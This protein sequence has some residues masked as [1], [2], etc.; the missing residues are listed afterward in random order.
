MDKN[1]EY[2]YMITDKKDKPIYWAGTKCP[3]IVKSY[4]E[5]FKFCTDLNKYKVMRIPLIVLE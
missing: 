3:I 4:R 2:V 1:I 5:I